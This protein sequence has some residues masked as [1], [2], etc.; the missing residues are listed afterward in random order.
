MN[1][2]EAVAADLPTIARMGV[3]FYALTQYQLPYSK[4]SVERWLGVMLEQHMVAVTEHDGQ[5]IGFSGG[6]VS[7]FWLN[8]DYLCGQELFYWVEPEHRNKGAA[9]PLLRRME[10]KAKAAGCAIWS[11]LAIESSDPERAEA[12][13][14]WLGYQPMERP[15]SKILINVTQPLA[16]GGVSLLR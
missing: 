10:A 1:I 11:M 8:D 3:R 12:I 9:L 14:R 13:Y 5:I 16:V 2:R 7:P 4:E 6:I 15:W